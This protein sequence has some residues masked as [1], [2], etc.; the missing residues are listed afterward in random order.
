MMKVSG[1]PLVIHHYLA[2]ARDSLAISALPGLVEERLLL[3]RVVPGCQGFDGLVGTGATEK[4]SSK[5]QLIHLHL[6]QARLNF[7]NNT[8]RGYICVLYYI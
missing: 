2:R 1:T 6:W 4:A 8:T 3:E 7:S 5:I